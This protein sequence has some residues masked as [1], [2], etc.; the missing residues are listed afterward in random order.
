M[1]PITFV[2]PTHLVDAEVLLEQR[3]DALLA[4]DRYQH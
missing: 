4:Q 2:T 1:S 3:L